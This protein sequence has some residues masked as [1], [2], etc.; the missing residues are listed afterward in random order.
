MRRY[1]NKP[2][3]ENMRIPA[4]SI[5]QPFKPQ[6]KRT[7]TSLYL[8]RP[9]FSGKDRFEG[10]SIIQTGLDELKADIEEEIIPYREKYKDT[11]IQLG[12]IGYDSQEKLKLVK[13]YE[14]RL[15]NKKLNAENNE[16]FIQASKN[17]L[18]FE[19]YKNNIDEFERTAE[20]VQKNDYYSNPEILKTIDKN[21][22]KMIRD[23]K[24]FAKLEPLYNKTNETKA[25]MNTDLEQISS[26]NLPDF[27]N[28]IK[29][30]DEQ[31]KMAAMLMFIS[32]YPDT[33]N[34]CNEYKSI[35]KDYNEK[36]ILMYDLLDRIGRLSYN[37][38]KFKERK[39]N[40]EEN[41]ND[42]N[43]FIE[44]NKSYKTENISEKEIR[45]T[46]DKL[47]KNAD[48]TIAMHS[49][50]LQNYAAAHPAEISPRIADRTFKMQAKILKQLNTMIWNEK[51]K[52]Y[53]R[54]NQDFTDKNY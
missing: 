46:Y 13:D 35:L 48:N 25:Q 51:Q 6:N 4:I 34:I 54:I 3:G 45:T 1:N 42:I 50:N 19:K 39:N 29:A 12:K 52:F 33:T 2:Q 47:L 23:A 27:H 10:K 53:N 37:I 32:E 43:K 7:N 36:K 24:E 30:L 14:T 31:N 18:Q 16:T 17:A 41:I 44:E 38:Q 40:F 5:S 8:N 28:K 9:T 20:F 49:K 26:K 21:R 15:M 11:F 22:S